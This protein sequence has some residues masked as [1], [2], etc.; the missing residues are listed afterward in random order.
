MNYDCDYDGY[1][2]EPAYP[3]VAIIKIEW[4]DIQF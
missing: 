2:F 4:K 1:I 3:V